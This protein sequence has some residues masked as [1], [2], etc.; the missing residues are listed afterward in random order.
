MRDGRVANSVRGLLRKCLSLGDV[1]SDVIEEYVIEGRDF[2]V[3]D[4]ELREPYLASK[5]Y[6]HTHISHQALF[7]NVSQASGS[8]VGERMAKGCLG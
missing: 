1:C 7:S 5:P 3:D 6:P 8:G 2:L 4:E